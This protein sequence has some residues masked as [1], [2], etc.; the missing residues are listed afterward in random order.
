LLDEEV[1]MD[2]EIETFRNMVL[3][4]RGSRRRGARPYTASMKARALQLVELLRERGM[5]AG[6][7]AKQIGICAMTLQGWRKLP[8]SKGLVPVRIVTE[9]QM[10]PT[11]AVVHVLSPRGYRVEMADLAT[12]VAVLRELG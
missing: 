8:V 6:A 1:H 11:T 7:A 3:R 4:W 12:A 5:T 9:A 10:G 2:R